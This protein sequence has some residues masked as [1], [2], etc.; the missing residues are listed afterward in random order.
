[1]TGL[2]AGSRMTLVSWLAHGPLGLVS[3]REKEQEKK[4]YFT[5]GNGP[6]LGWIHGLFSFWVLPDECFSDFGPQLRPHNV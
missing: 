5:L 2:T 1:M 6:G 3:D 4:T